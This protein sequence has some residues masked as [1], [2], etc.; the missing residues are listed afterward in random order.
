MFMPRH[1]MSKQLGA[2]TFSWQDAF[3]PGHKELSRVY[4]HDHMHY[5]KG[6]NIDNILRVNVF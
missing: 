4:S 5:V 2:V 1:I 6:I 3:M